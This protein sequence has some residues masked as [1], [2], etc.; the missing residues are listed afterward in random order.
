MCVAY[1]SGAAILGVIAS[2]VKD[3]PAC[4]AIIIVKS[5]IRLD[6]PFVLALGIIMVHIPSRKK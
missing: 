6:Y 5:N 4:P 3:Y 2:K 1:I